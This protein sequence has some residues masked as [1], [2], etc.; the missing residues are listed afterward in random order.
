MF[1]QLHLKE[2]LLISVLHMLNNPMYTTALTRDQDLCLPSHVFNHLIQ[3]TLL[4]YP[5]NY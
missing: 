1:L 5:N 3:T 2:A 4:S